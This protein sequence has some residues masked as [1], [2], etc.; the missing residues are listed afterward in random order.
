MNSIQ[1]QDILKTMNNSFFV[2]REIKDRLKPET[3]LE[4]KD[5][6]NKIYITIGS[7]NYNVISA[8]YK[9]TYIITKIEIDKS[10]KIKKTIN[11]SDS[12]IFGVR[13]NDV[14]AAFCSIQYN[15]EQ[16]NHIC[17]I[18]IDEEKFWS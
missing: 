2:S 7:N 12:N 6:S 10:F 17:V 3:L 15:Q 1:I 4:D 8:E 13:L 16:K 9:G 14:N 5:T 11:I 18:R